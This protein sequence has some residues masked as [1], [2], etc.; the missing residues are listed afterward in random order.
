MSVL[1]LIFTSS[2][3]R[4]TTFH[5]ETNPVRRVPRSF[6]R[7]RRTPL[8]RVLT[9]FRFSIVSR[10]H[11]WKRILFKLKILGTA[12]LI[13]FRI[14]QGNKIFGTEHFIQRAI[15]FNTFLQYASSYVIITL[16]S[17]SMY[18]ENRRKICWSIFDDSI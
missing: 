6:N 7:T 11:L 4:D 9:G 3:I 18:S 16:S 15:P 13:V 14:Y 8:H 17:L 10:D 12:K 1:T 5:Y 2:T